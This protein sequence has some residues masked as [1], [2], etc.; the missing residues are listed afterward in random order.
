MGNKTLQSQL[1]E[2]QK[3]IQV[4][5]K[6]AKN[7]HF[8]NTYATLEQVLSEVKPVLSGL[9][10]LLTQPINE[11]GIGTVLALGEE[12]IESFIPMPIGLQPQALGSA[13]TYFRRYT[14]TSL[15]ALEIDDDDANTASEHKQSD[16]NDL[17]WLNKGTKEFDLAKQWL[18]EGGTI[19]KIKTKYK[20]SKEVEKLLIN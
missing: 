12:S 3:S 18:T 2:F 15:L 9:D 14:L 20:L 6:D 19:D 10:I 13:I 17:P 11:K 1:L 7:P 4:I 16:Q 8:K 5:K